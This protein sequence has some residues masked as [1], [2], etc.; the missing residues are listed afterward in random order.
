MNGM[1]WQEEVSPEEVAKRCG[2][3]EIQIQRH[4]RKKQD[5]VL[6]KVE[7]MELTCKNILRITENRSVV[8]QDFEMLK[9]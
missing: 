5:E 7:E 9:K 6:G 1:R 2:L 3:E 4:E 8:Q